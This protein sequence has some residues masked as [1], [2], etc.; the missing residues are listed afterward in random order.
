[1]IY[2]IFGLVILVSVAFGLYGFLKKTELDAQVSQLEQEREALHQELSTL[3]K[4]RHVPGL[5]EKGRRIKDEI[6][7]RLKQAREEA[8]LILEQAQTRADGILTSA[9]NQATDQAKR[10]KTEAEAALLNARDSLRI[11]RAQ[12]DALLAESQKNAR[13]VL[14]EARKDA[15]EKTQKAEETLE[16]ATTSAVEIRLKA[17]RRAEEIAGKAYEILKSHDHYEAAARAYKNQVEGYSG[18]YIVP[19]SH[20]LDELAED[21]GFHDAGGK[22]KLARER[23][24][25]MERNG[26]AATCNYAEGWKRDYAINFVLSAFNGKVDSILARVKTANQGKQIQEIRD[27]FA[28]VNDN[29]SVFKGAGINPEFLEARLEEYK[30]AVA[31][32][33]LK[34]KQREEQRAIREQIREEAKAKREYER[35]IKQAHRVEELLTRALEKARRE[36]ELASDEEKAKYEEELDGLN[37]KLKE[38]EERNQR[39]ISMAQQTKCGHVYIISNIGSFGEDV[40]KIGLTRRLEPLDRVRE[41]GDASVPFAFD[42][43]AMIYSENAPNLETSLHKKFL[44]MQVNK[45]NRRKE[46]FRV[47]LQ[48]IKKALDEMGLDARWTMTADAREYRETL[49]LE[50]AMKDDPRLKLKW[51]E[52]Q[53]AAEEAAALRGEVEEEEELVEAEEE[54]EI[55]P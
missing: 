1:M 50:T 14:K 28:L 27:A 51:L 23:T 36:F 6:D 31:V 47:S 9:T 19:A 3:D 38:A 7:A 45:V 39:A 22:L 46:F 37:L 41:L 5:I 16:W 54:A 49:A 25:I 13:E 2:V 11:A 42:V 35:A 33:N 44:S 53:D 12:A 26:T 29:G 32:Q 40:Y 55:M 18:V 21:Y 8:D 17:E 15:K 48:D 10:M 20:F 43:H 4:I 30:W 24:R 34:D 52:E